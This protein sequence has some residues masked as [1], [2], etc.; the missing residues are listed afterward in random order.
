MTKKTKKTSL[1][2]KLKLWL[3]TLV[4]KIT[5]RYAAF[6]SLYHRLSELHFSLSSG[7][8]LSEEALKNSRAFKQAAKRH[9]DLVCNNLFKDSNKKT[10]QMVKKSSVSAFRDK[11]LLESEL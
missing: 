8:R 11:Y 10:K 2:L 5:V 9:S 4:Q 7:K 1:L 6:D 3:I